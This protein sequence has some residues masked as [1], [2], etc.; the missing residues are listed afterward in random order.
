MARTKVIDVNLNPILAKDIPSFAR[1]LPIMTDMQN[2]RYIDTGIDRKRPGYLEEWDTTVAEPIKF[3][4]PENNGYAIDGKGGIFTLGDSINK[5]YTLAPVSS[6][7]T[8]IKYDDKLLVGT[9][10]PVIEIDNVT[11]S[12]VGNGVPSAKFI[13]IINDHA[14]YL[15][16]HPTNFVSS[17]PGNP[18][19]VDDTLGARTYVI[20]K[21]GT[22]QNAIDHNENLLV[23]KEEDIEI[24]S[25]RGGDPPFIRQ[26]GA[27]IDDVGLGAV[28]SL[29]RADQRI[30]FFGSDGDFYKIEG[31]APIKISTN[32]RLELDS[33]TDY[34]KWEGYDITKEN[35][36]MWI[37]RVSG[38]TLLFDYRKDRWLE[39]NWWNGGCK[40]ALPFSSYME[41]GN[42]K[43]NQYFGSGKF[44]G[45]IHNW[46]YEHKDDNGEPIR[47]SKEFTVPLS[48][49][50][51]RGNVRRIN[52]RRE[53]NQAISTETS[54][55]F[56]VRTRFDKGPWSHYEHLT[57]GEAGDNTPH[58]QMDG[59]GL[60]RE[61][62]V[63]IVETDAVDFLLTNIY[64][65]VERMRN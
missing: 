32:Y 24:W 25:Y 48:G 60:G 43:I 4:I 34:S 46:S 1:K 10:G 35:V 54:P 27:K 42:K 3:L 45:K 18:K 12:L 31:F 29:V 13:R 17:V 40:Q 39:D 41:H 8:Y 6:R 30:W 20:Q 22:I 52:F 53:A 28:D 58:A 59:V 62:D 44:D 19:S 63:E 49:S 21:T 51:F 56:M 37:N 15:G 50:G 2:V 7:P 23:F 55:V 11:V 14:I 57:L 64:I 36:I 16:H 9:G 5:I 61:M 33:A 65:T 47:V 26:P 38:K